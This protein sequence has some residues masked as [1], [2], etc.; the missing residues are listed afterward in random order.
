M[1][2]DPASRCQKS[3]DENTPELDHNAPLLPPLPSPAPSAFVARATLRLL[4]LRTGVPDHAVADLRMKKD[5]PLAQSALSL[6]NGARDE[7]C[8]YF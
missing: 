2:E 1:R 4:A 8:A 5:P 7:P 3:A 6:K